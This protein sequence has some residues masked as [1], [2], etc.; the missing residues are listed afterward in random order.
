MGSLKKP[1]LSTG[2]AAAVITVLIWTGF[3]VIAR[4]AGTARI[5]TPFDIAF[6]RFVGAALVLVPVG[7]WLVRRDGLP[8]WLGLSPLPFKLT[9]GIGLVGGVGYAMLAYSGFFFA[10]AAHASV[11]MPGTLPLSTA[12]MAW[13]ILHEPIARA[14]AWGLALILAGDLL[15][16]GASLLKAFDGSTVWQ[17]DLLFLCASSCWAVY[18][19]TARRH[20]LDAVKATV[21]ISVF[22]VLT[23][24][25]VYAI[26]VAADALPTAI[27]SQLLHAPWRELAFHALVQGVGS[28]VVS[29]I[30]YT[31][32]IHCFGPVRSSMLTA[33]VPGLSA[34]A[35]VYFLGE[36]LSWNLWAG[37]ALVTLGIVF[38]VR[39]A[40]KKS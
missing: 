10:P 20:A 16:G 23:Y 5:L 22:A 35:A 6:A 19:V 11:L 38:G 15:V 40:A 33:V 8:G 12:L 7:W 36:P 4:A 21:A 34:L 37:L 30:S 31:T 32:M 17:G 27:A 24:V 39:A 13:L 14:R 9:A 28:V 2:I 3:I 25:P 1:S 18:S 29:G 26:L